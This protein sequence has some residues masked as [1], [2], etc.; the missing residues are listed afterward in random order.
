MRYPITLIP[1]KSE[2]ETKMAFD[3]SSE[4]KMQKLLILAKEF[5]KDDPKKG[6]DY[7]RLAI[8][9][10]TGVI[11]NCLSEIDMCLLAIQDKSTVRKGD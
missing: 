9:A 2:K 1:G 5:K 3:E 4:N 11:N 10:A 8:N 7:Y 6:H